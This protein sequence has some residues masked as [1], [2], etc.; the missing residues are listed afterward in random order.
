[1]NGGEA[2]ATFGLPSFRASGAERGQRWR[3]RMH[4][5]GPLVGGDGV[6][7]QPVE[8]DCEALVARFLEAELAAERHPASLRD[9]DKLG[10]VERD[11]TA[12]PECRSRAS[13]H[14]APEQRQRQCD[15]QTRGDQRAARRSA[16]GTSPGK[17][18]ASA[19]GTMAS[20]SVSAAPTQGRDAGPQKTTRRWRAEVASERHVLVEIPSPWTLNIPTLRTALPRSRSVTS[21][22]ADPTA[23]AG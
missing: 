15:E 20:Q 16:P 5:A 23:G 2:A 22:F 21:G 14:Q 12:A 1:M 19:D 9:L 7:L 11:C 4:A 18:S 8:R 10:V 17:A 13:F 3:V 6:L